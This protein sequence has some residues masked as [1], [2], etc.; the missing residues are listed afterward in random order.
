M[1]TESNE[2]PN[3]F[4][5][6]LPDQSTLSPALI[7][8]ACQTLK[9]NRHRFLLPRTT[10]SIIN[11]LAGLARD[12]RDRAFPFR[13]R[14]L[15]E[16]P[17]LTGFSPETLARR[18]DAFF[19]RIT[20]ENLRALLLQDL[21]HEKRL[22]ELVSEETETGS[23]AS[24][25]HGPGLLVQITGGLLPNPSLTSLIL[26]LLARSAQFIK[27][28]SGTALIPRLFAHSLYQVEPKLG[29]CLEI[30]DWKGG[31]EPLEQALLSEANC[32]TATGN[33]ETLTAIRQ[34]LPATVRFIGYGHRVSFAYVAHESLAKINLPRVIS[35]VGDDVVAWNQL[36]CLS[37]HVIYL[38]T[39]GATDPE[40]FADALARELASREADEPRGALPPD[41]SGAI[42][43]RRM[44]YQV[45][46]SHD[47]S[48][49]LWT[50]P[51]STDWTV[52]FEK[53]P[54]FQSS[55]L[56]RFI[57]IKP[58]AGLDQ[59]L[60]AAAPVA[61]KVSTVGLSAPINR[62]QEIATRLAAWGVTRVCP[63]GQMQDPP[64][65][66]RHDGRP[67]LAD[68]VTWTDWEF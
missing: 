23:R 62:A 49:R 11:V 20:P 19:A 58:I 7:T 10:T 16:A 46:A 68:L 56:N 57:Y 41:E 29:A 3:Y 14:V 5:A 43:T 51:G 61:G 65:T 52:I 66:W 64:L 31:T 8:E 6:D 38:E 24:I 4:L 17:A 48:T 44:F 12:W 32:V 35:A 33:D 28:A 30:A 67:S 9:R 40:T 34:R 22:D 27:C 13:Q 59:L 53:D 21:G 54:Q 37:P 39:G 26:G 45:R 18:L 50:S 1:S 36:G 42:A 60:E 2:L 63:V 47:E 55:C 15:Q 25:V